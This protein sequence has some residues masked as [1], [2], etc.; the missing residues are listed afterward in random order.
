MNYEAM[1][2][3]IF[4]KIIFFCL[5]SCALMQ[6]QE[7]QE[8]MP[9]KQSEAQPKKIRLACNKQIINVSQENKK[10]D[11]KNDSKDNVES[12]KAVATAKADEELSQHL[13]SMQKTAEK[14]GTASNL[15]DE[16]L[17]H[18]ASTNIAAKSNLTYDN[19]Q[20]EP[21]IASNNAQ[22]LQAFDDEV[23]LI[24]EKDDSTMQTLHEKP[25]E[26]KNLLDTPHAIDENVSCVGCNN[27]STSYEEHT[28][29]ECNQE[30]P[31]ARKKIFLGRA[32]NYAMIEE[33]CEKHFSV[34]SSIFATFA[35]NGFN[36]CGRQV[37]LSDV[38][39]AQSGFA[40]AADTDDATTGRLGFTVGDI[41]LESRLSARVVGAPEDDASILFLDENGPGNLNNTGLQSQFGNRRLQ[42]Y[43]GLLAPVLVDLKTDF[44]K[45][46]AQS[47]FMYRFYL[48][49]EKNI[50]GVVGAIFSVVSVFQDICLQFERGKL[51]DRTEFAAKDAT[52]RESSI[53][54]FFN[55]FSALEDFFK[56]AVLE[57][58]GITINCREQNFGFGDFYIF[59]LVDFAPLFCH[60]DAL[61]LGLNLIFPT[62]SQ[63]KGH[64]LFEI[65]LDEGI[66]AT[67]FFATT[68][69]NS[70]N[71]WLNPSFYLAG[72][73]AIGGGSSRQMR[74]PILVTHTAVDAG[75]PEF[76]ANDANRVTNIPGLQAPVMREFF[77]LSFSELDSLVPLFADNISTV[78]FYR[79]PQVVVGIG[80][81][82]YDLF[83]CN[84]RFN[85]VY[86]FIARGSN[87]ICPLTCDTSNLTTFATPSLC[88]LNE[89]SHNIGFNLTYK[90]SC[91]EIN[92]GA[93]FV[94]AGKNTI[95]KNQAFA[96]FIAVF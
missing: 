92:F 5:F 24:D 86:N 36:N 69:F 76:L 35:F 52:Y 82:F 93:E 31:P 18:L 12:I 27:K 13:E 63:P 55:D 87:E 42:Q 66:F 16:A 38:L 51:F 81:Y 91:G 84:F 1:K 33:E 62:S 80:N 90:F 94:L 70:G 4:L 21:S 79:G 29:N 48:T 54:R 83:S 72:N 56:R 78:R 43:L 49:E 3:Y 89:Y 15:F 88:D 60:L 73:F 9:I 19:V 32:Y 34:P 53:G 2:K 75:P 57:P 47:G 59:G 45:F 7:D 40:G 30:Y 37:P 71:R 11:A 68:I 46:A 61:Q 6:A 28:C 44:S 50:A 96:S 74:V 14:K 65:P 10:N 58:K 41:F 22:D 8:R 23:A 25:R 64:K 20:V 39:L 77:A 95:K 85:I 26:I 17:S 67:E